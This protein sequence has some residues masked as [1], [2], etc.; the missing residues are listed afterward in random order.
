MQ[1]INFYEL[2]KLSLKL[3]ILHVRLS[4]DI[5]HHCSCKNFHFTFLDS[6]IMAAVIS[7]NM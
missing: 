4:L 5:N 2:H 7:R 6:L 3:H 1:T